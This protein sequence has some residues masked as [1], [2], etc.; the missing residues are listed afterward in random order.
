MNAP[1]L[2]DS[3]SFDAPI[4]DLRG[5]QTGWSEDAY[6]C[7]AQI[8]YLR[9]G[10]AVQ[11]ARLDGKQPVVV[12]IRRSDVA[13]MITSDWKVKDARRGTIFNVRA[14]VPTEDRAWLEITAESGVAT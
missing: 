2:V 4:Y 7:R 1:K 5:L 10:E 3:L 9:G 12:T 14:I 8:R 6:S 11:A 13:D